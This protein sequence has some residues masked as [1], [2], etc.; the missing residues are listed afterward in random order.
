VTRAKWISIALL[1]GATAVSRPSGANPISWNFAI[2][3]T[4]LGVGDLD[5]GFQSGAMLEATLTFDPMAAEFLWADDF[6]EGE[7]CPA[8]SVRCAYRLPISIS[9]IVE[10]HVIEGSGAGVAV[11]T[12]DTSL[13]LSLSRFEYDGETLED[14]SSIGFTLGYGRGFKPTSFAQQ[15][16]GAL[17]PE[18]FEHIFSLE[19]DPGTGLPTVVIGAVTA[20]ASVPEN[21]AAAMLL[22]TGAALIVRISRTSGKAAM[23][24]SRVAKANPTD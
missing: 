2:D 22:I 18:G 10:G 14:R 12:L 9:A 20:I 13:A 23:R 3:T 6:E 8:E 5:P 1:L 15:G 7:G 24:W 16:F 11:L 21:S 19:L 17:P 4:I